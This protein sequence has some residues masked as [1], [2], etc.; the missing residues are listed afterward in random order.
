MN[1]DERRLK[2]GFLSAFIGVDR[3]PKIVVSGLLYDPALTTLRRDRARKGKD[4][5]GTKM[6]P[7]VPFRMPHE[8]KRD[9]LPEEP[10][11]GEPAQP[12]NARCISGLAKVQAPSWLKVTHKF[13]GRGVF[14]YVGESYAWS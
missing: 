8:R 11:S 1:T 6:N 9:W 10:F 13:P 14:T 7:R 12:L 4:H 3:R 5:T 2:T